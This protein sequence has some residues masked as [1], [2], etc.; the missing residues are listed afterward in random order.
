MM[1]LTLLLALCPVLVFGAETRDSKV[2]SDRADV[3]S[4]GRWI[5]N[6]FPKALAEAKRSGKPLLAVLRCVP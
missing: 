6:D 5:Y 2:L 4:G 1:R 3:L